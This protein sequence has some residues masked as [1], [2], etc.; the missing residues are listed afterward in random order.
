VYILSS[1]SKNLYIGVTNNLYRRTSEHKRVV[2]QCF[3]SRYRT[4]RLVY[5][6]AFADIRAAIAQEKQVK[7]WRREKK[8]D[9]IGKKNPAWAD[10]AEEWFGRWLEKR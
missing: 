1:R 6:E 10:I 9:L 2:A 3:S 4:S 5:Y 7:S 8:I